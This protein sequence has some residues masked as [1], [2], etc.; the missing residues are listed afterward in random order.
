M[1]LLV[2]LS[3]VVGGP[4]LA[5]GLPHGFGTGGFVCVKICHG[6][7]GGNLS[8][9]VYCES[10]ARAEYI[11][12]SSWVARERLIEQGRYDEAI[13]A[14]ERVAER[15]PAS[16]TVLFDVRRRIE[17]LKVQAAMPK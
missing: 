16:A 2:G 17:D 14:F 13:E 6:G 10:L 12:A 9:F 3:G 8:L 5:V 1:L 11:E 15:H 4:V 7:H